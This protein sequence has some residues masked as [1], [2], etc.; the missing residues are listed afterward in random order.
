MTRKI[1]HIDMDCFYAAIE[2]RD[3]PRLRHLPIAVGSSQEQ[4]G[5][6]CT[7]N[8]I[9]RQFGVRSAMSAGKAKQLCPDLIIIPPNMEKYR[10]AARAIRSIFYQYTD[11]VEP[12]SLDEAYLDVTDSPHYYGSATWIAGAIRQEILKKLELTASAGVSVNK[13]LAKVASDWHKPNGQYVIPPLKIAQFVHALPVG[14]LWGVGKVTEKKLHELNMLTCGDLQ[15]VSLEKLCKYFGSF[16]ERLYELCRGID[17]RCIETDHVRKS[18]SVE[19]TYETDLRHPTACLE[20]LPA[21]LADL[22]RR[23]GRY[24]HRAI[25]KQFIKIKFADFQQLTVECLSG[26]P[27]LEV[28]ESLCL[29]GYV[30]EQKPVRLLGVGVRFRDEIEVE[31]MALEW[32]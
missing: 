30:R 18:V 31:Q 15:Q 24:T 13:F 32:G 29:K 28:Y 8:Y 17:E 11:K 26:A 3:D 5:V 21:L 25:H 12:L 14:K 7:S 27:L 23:L 6:L 2:M 22:K 10:D 19:N 16:G 9:A 20:A 1:I 4:R